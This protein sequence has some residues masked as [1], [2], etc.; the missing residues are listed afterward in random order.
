MPSG[1]QLVALRC[2]GCG[3][4]MLGGDAVEVDLAPAGRPFAEPVL[5][6]QRCSCTSGAHAPAVLAQ[7]RRTLRPFPRSARHHAAPPVA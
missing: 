2:Y 1:K 3:R 4:P 5:M 6:H 7:A